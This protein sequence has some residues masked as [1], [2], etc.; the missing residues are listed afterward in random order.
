[1]KAKHDVD[2]KKPNVI[3]ITFKRLS[4]KVNYLS[5]V[6]YNKSEREII[7]ICNE[8]CHQVIFCHDL[9]R[10]ESLARSCGTRF[11]SSIFVDI[12]LTNEK[13]DM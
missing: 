5:Y 6:T 11:V 1:L 9:T 3:I 13:I 10:L 2:M 8:S 7:W 12:R 4:S